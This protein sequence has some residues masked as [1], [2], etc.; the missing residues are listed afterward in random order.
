MKKEDLN[1]VM[2]MMM[3]IHYNKQGAKCDKIFKLILSVLNVKLPLPL[4]L[5]STM[6]VNYRQF[7][8]QND[9]RHID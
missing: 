1:R 8:M 3:M 5:P 4:W 7:V 6:L 9:L 2:M